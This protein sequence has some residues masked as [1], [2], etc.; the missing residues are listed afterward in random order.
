M[1]L[2]S[3]GLIAALTFAAITVFWMLLIGNQE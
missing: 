3:I 2:I 1:I